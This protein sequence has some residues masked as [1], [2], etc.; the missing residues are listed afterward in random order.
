MSI[1][2]SWVF[3][4]QKDVEAKS[5]E[6]IVINLVSDQRLVVISFWYPR[7][8]REQLTDEIF[9]IIKSIR[10]RNESIG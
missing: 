10:L 8:L 3:R 2:P 9:S 6:V 7:A 1:E 5:L 4:F